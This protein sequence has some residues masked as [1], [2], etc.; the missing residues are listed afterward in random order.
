MRPVTS[1]R[2]NC[3]NRYGG[4]EQQGTCHDV[5]VPNRQLQGSACGAT[6]GA[7]DGLG[8][9]SIVKQQRHPLLWG[10]TVCIS[11]GAHRTNLG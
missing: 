11:C 2:D 5:V 1:G 10:Q 9:N 4:E 7:E 6:S 3:D 8:G